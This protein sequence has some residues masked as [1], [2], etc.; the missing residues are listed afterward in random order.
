MGRPAELG[1]KTRV[2]PVHLWPPWGAEKEKDK[3]KREKLES[4][5]LKLE[6]LELDGVF[7]AEV[8]PG[9]D[10][11]LD[12]VIQALSGLTSRVAELADQV[13]ELKKAREGCARRRRGA[14]STMRS[15]DPPSRR[16]P[17]AH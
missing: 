9:P 8:L 13:E 16:S 6:K 11:R 12:Q 10:P 14:V 3:D 5:E 2:R 4:K 1:R 17:S 7:E 15:L